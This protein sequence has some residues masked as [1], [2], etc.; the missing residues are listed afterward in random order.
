MCGYIGHILL[1]V[2][3]VYFCVCMSY[4]FIAYFGVHVLYMC[5][6]IIA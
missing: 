3:S 2:F 1:S 6:Y 4:L 5:M